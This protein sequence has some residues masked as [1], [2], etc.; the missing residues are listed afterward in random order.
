MTRLD[1]LLFAEQDDPGCGA[2]GAILD[3]YV[4]LELG[5]Q[6]AAAIYPQWETHLRACPAC[7]QDYDGLVE[8]VRRYGDRL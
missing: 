8:A 4:D 3:A 2:G 7:R 5:G 6:D 1:D